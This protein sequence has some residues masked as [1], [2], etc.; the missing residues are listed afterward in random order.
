MPHEIANE[1]DIKRR[2]DK[3]SLDKDKKKSRE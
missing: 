3:V 1:A 2:L